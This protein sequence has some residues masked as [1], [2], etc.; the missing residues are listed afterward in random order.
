MLEMRIKRQYLAYLKEAKRYCEASLDGAAAALHRFE[1]Y[2]RFRDFKAFHI[3]Q[4]VGFKRHLV[5]LNNTRTGRPL[6]KATL[7]STLTALK[8]FSSGSRGGQAF[9]RG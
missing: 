3:E 9:A 6:S 5:S 4:A 2:N 8:F 1:V 7:Y